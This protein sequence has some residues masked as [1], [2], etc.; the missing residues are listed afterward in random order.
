MAAEPP[1]ALGPLGHRWRRRRGQRETNGLSGRRTRL[2][3]INI[4]RLLGKKGLLSLKQKGWSGKHSKVIKSCNMSRHLSLDGLN[5]WKNSG[6]CILYFFSNQST[7]Q[8]HHQ[9]GHPLRMSERKATHR[10]TYGD[11]KQICQVTSK[12]MACMPPKL[13]GQK[14][15][16]HPQWFW[17]RS[18][19]FGGIPNLENNTPGESLRFRHLAS[20]FRNWRNRWK[21]DLGPKPTTEITLLWS[22]SSSW[23]LH[24]LL[25]PEN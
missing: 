17:W 6:T 13:G 12:D 24:I 23:C 1:N 4:P 7:E 9:W 11:N 5:Y 20:Q 25:H 22:Y 15:Q 18:L 21:F 14:A 3:F 16:H 10:A 2:S 8:K 19:W